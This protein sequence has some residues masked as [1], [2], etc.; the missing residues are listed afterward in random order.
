MTAGGII[1]YIVI[2]V[3]YICFWR[4]CRAQGL[5]R[6]EFPY[7]GYFQPWSTIFALCFEICI[8]VCY[9]YVNF[10]PGKFDITSFFTHYAMVFAAIIFFCCWKFFKGTKFV[11]PHEAD[12]VWDRPAIERYELTTLD[13]DIGFWRELFEI[14]ELKKKK[15]MEGEQELVF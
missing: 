12:L 9:G 2:C 11:R 4:A 8:L 6:R 1:D 15:T 13:Q 3:N 10:M 5:N 14:L 7:Y